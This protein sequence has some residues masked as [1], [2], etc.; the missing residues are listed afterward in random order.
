MLKGYTMKAITLAALVVG[1]T[2]GA[3]AA[4][5]TSGNDEVLTN[6][7]IISMTAANVEK[8]LLLSKVA[9]TRNAFDVSVAGLVT[10]NQGKVNQDVLKA[11][12]TAAANPKLGP[13]PVRTPEVLDNQSVI[14]MV[15]GKVPKAVVLMKIQ[16]TKGAYDMS[17]AGLV[18]LTQAK[19]SSDVIQ[20]MTAKNG[21]GK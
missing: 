17:S 11:M 2:I 5:Q 6:E 15:T 7:K 8:D 13:P 16:N 14:T 12:L 3:P 18:S 9:T 19:V 21:E 1:L 10:L 20:V 4:A